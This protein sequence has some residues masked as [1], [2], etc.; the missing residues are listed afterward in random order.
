MIHSANSHGWNQEIVTQSRFPMW[1]AGTQVLDPLPVIFRKAHHQEAGIRDRVMN[2]IPALLDGMQVSK[3]C[4]QCCT[5]CL[6][7][8][9]HWLWCLGMVSTCGL[10][11]LRFVCWNPK[12]QG[13]IL[14][15]F[16][17]GSPFLKS[18]FTL[19]ADREKWCCGSRCWLECLRPPR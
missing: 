9:S 2:Q 12:L 16:L 19:K 3:Q 5:E 4:L 11:L 1:V 14:Q 18:C 17:R 7:Q 13:I 10:Y 8:Y 15:L 6:S